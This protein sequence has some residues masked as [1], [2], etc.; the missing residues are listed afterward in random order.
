MDGIEY[1]LVAADGLDFN[2]ALIVNQS[3]V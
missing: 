3:G 2:P 1:R